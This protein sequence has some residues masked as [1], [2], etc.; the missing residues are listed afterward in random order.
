LGARRL[1]FGIFEADLS[2]GELRRQGVRIKLQDQPFQVLV[3]LLERPGELVTRQEL[4]KRLWPDV[5]VDLDRGLNKA[6]N[7]LREVLGD[8]AENPRFVETVPQ[9]GYRF[10]APVGMASSAPSPAYSQGRLSP[11]L[12]PRRG[13]LALIGGLIA[14]PVA[15]VGFHRLALPRRRI[16]SIAVLPLE[17]LSG[18]PAQ[19]YLSDGM[20]DQLIGEIAQIASLRVISRTSVMRYKIGARQSLPDIARELN[21]DAIVEGTVSQSGS[22]LRISANLILAHDDRHLWSAEYERDLTDILALQRSVAR[23]VAREIRI[24]LTPQEQTLLARTRQVSP[25]AHQAFLK[26]NFFLHRG[27]QNLAKSTDCFREAIGLDPSHAEAHAGLAQALIYA[28]IFGLRPPAE[29][30][31]EARIMALRALELDESNASAHNV[32]ADIKKGFDWDL[33]G[34]VTEYR[35]ALQ[36]SPSHLLAR[37]WFAE[38]LTRM[39]RYDDALAES[40]R[41]LE[42]DPVS[43]MSLSNRAMLLFRARRF[44]EA[45]RF[46]RQALELDPQF[47][48]ALWWQGLSY[49]GIRDFSRSIGC[50]TKAA[51]MDDGPVFRALLGHVFGLAGE[52]TKALRML[53]ELTA[54][55]SQ[56]Y[57]SP[58][59]FAVVYAGIDDADSTFHWL[60]R[61]YQT[62]ASRIHELSWMYFD[63][64]RSDP[65]YSDL[66]KRIGL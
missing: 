15:F 61:A 36:L 27:I 65:R 47:L 14:I 32:L 1:R 24:K 43:P 59:D 10:L 22:K 26:G 7:R 3:A 2:S 45:I 5:A 38:C 53:E 55:S 57:V 4:Q 62:R 16:E 9:R 35:R 33:E 40:D 8:D 11:R 50:L 28:A 51:G 20:T 12:M 44:E 46:S 21:V 52:K 64:F 56:R 60:E 39:G 49:A 30:F 58:M 13:S 17:N 6:I 34:A 54:L 66:M 19:E 25:E 31:S 29:A 42:L 41:A 23:D 48:N 63:A 18:D 37:L